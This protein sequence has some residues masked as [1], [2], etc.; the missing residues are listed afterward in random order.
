MS[1]FSS[2]ALLAKSNYIHEKKLEQ[3]K[4]I[5]FGIAHSCV[6]DRKDRLKCWGENVWGQLGYGDTLNRYGLPKKFVHLDK[7]KIIQIALGDCHTCALFEQGDVKCWGCNLFGQLGSGDYIS[8][9]K[10]SEEFVDLDKEKATQ[11]TLGRYHS[12]ATLESGKTK[13]WGWITSI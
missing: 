8:R 11:I 9:S 5:V 7:Q 13:C 10:P 12:C 4:Q 2:S 3:P 6:I 1:F